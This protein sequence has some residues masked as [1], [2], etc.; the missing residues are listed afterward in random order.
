MEKI[1]HKARYKVTLES[2]TTFS[3]CQKFKKLEAAKFLGFLK[4]PP[5]SSSLLAILVLS[6]LYFGTSDLACNFIPYFVWI[7]ALKLFMA[8]S[9]QANQSFLFIICIY[10][11]HII[12]SKKERIIKPTHVNKTSQKLI[13]CNYITLTLRSKMGLIFGTYTKHGSSSMD[14]SCGPGLWTTP[15]F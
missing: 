12:K 9:P 1:G 6:I 14:Y 7:F 15:N 11:L 2:K 13:I 5:L 3:Q 10:L 4:L 8:F